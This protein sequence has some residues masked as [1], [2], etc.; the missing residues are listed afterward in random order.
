M[1]ENPIW[2][3]PWRGG[4]AQCLAPLLFWR[5]GLDI[6]ITLRD[7]ITLILFLFTFLGFIGGIVG[8]YVLMKIDIVRLQSHADS[9]SKALQEIKIVQKE[10]KGALDQVTLAVTELRTFLQSHMTKNED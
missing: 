2:L 3:I 1:A 4:D 5:F 8:V 10:L 6:T 7:L 9:F